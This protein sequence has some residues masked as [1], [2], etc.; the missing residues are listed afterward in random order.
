MKEE[1]RKEKDHAGHK[2]LGEE[3]LPKHAT[4]ISPFPFNPAL[5]SF[6]PYSLTLIKLR[7]SHLGNSSKLDCTRFGV[8]PPF[9]F[10]LSQL[11]LPRNL[12]IALKVVEG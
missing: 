6:P 10:F 12:L 5:R 1:R 4:L 7:K 9:C 3:S 8:G 11:F 2:I